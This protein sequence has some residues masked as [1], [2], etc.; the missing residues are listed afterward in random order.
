MPTRIIV[1]LGAGVKY[2]A[3]DRGPLTRTA[4]AR[5]RQH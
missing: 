1:R 3:G 5:A 2:F 4:A